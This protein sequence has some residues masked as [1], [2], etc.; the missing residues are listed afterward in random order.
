MAF[1][2]THP[3]CGFIDHII[4]RGMGA[5]GLIHHALCVLCLYCHIIP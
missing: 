1:L 3:V 5:V 4:Q 2:C